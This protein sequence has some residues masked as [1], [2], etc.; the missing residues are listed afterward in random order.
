MPLD[1]ERA[2]GASGLY[3]VS[4]DDRGRLTG[5]TPQGVGVSGRVSDSGDGTLDLADGRSLSFEAD[6]RRSGTGG[7][8]RGQMRLVVDAEGEVAGVLRTDGDGVL[9]VTGGR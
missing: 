4:V 2:G 9:W 8:E 5:T 6:Q 7:L 1:A 3:H